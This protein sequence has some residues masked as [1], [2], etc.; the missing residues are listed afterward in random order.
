[1]GIST[2]FYGS[3]IHKPATGFDKDSMVFSSP[4]VSSSEPEVSGE[5]D[6]DLLY[7]YKT[8]LGL[9]IIAWVSAHYCMTVKFTNLQL[10]LTKTPW[11]Y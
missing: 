8:H 9:H 11:F 7:L 3:K 6:K 2:S 1:M 4:S 5:E 10:V